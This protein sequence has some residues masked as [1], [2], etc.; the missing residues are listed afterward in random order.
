MNNLE[1]TTWEFRD[2]G[3]TLLIDK[4]LDWSSFDVVKKT[5]AL[6]NIRKVG[7]AG[8]LDPKAT[9]LLIVCTGRKTKSIDEF[10]HQEKEYEGILELGKRTPSYDSETEVT[11]HTDS[12]SI[13][14]AALKRVAATFVGTQMQVPPMYS[15]TRVEGVPLY[16]LARE[17]KTIDRDAKQIEIREFV[18]TD[19]K[20]PLATFRIVCSRGTY[21]RS[22]VHDLGEKLGCGATL[23]SLRRT[24]IGSMKVSDAFTI[25]QLIDLRDRIQLDFS[26]EH[27]ISP[28]PQRY[29]V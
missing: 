8:T 4:P 26:R 1:K 22:V 6:F 17:G 9:G 18:I 2:P 12:I 3:E 21:V 5:R 16:R 19:Y 28:E 29:T 15:A 11:E 20:S 10:Q 14:D 27:E 25:Q 24:R 7:H 13:D 23:L